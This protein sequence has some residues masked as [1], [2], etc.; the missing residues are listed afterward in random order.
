[1]GLLRPAPRLVRSSRAVQGNASQLGHNLL[2][3]IV[4]I[5]GIVPLLLLCDATGTRVYFHLLVY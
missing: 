3:S 5:E 1:M 4:Q 2:S